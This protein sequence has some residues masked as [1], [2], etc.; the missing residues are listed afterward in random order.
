MWHCSRSQISRFYPLSDPCIGPRGSSELYKK[1]E[2]AVKT[3]ISGAP[4]YGFCIT[5]LW[6]A[7]L[8]QDGRTSKYSSFFHTLSQSGSL[9]TQ[10]RPIYPTPPCVGL[11]GGEHTMIAY[12]GKMLIIRKRCGLSMR[13]TRFSHRMKTIS[14]GLSPL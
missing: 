13:L 14:S 2:P 8:V 4:S 11:S 1:Y 3:L 9:Q 12:H 10:A 6:F 5:S 7:S